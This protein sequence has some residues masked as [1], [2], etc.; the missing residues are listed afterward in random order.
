MYIFLKVKKHT[1]LLSIAVLS[2]NCRLFSQIEEKS[3]TS[4]LWNVIDVERGWS[5]A[6]EHFT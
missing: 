5:G 1:A 2:E 3:S 6:N 4:M